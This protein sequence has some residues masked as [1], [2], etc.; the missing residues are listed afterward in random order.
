LHGFVVPKCA[1]FELLPM[2][3]PTSVPQ[4]RAALALHRFGFGPK[5]GTIDAIASDPRGAL[6]AE[7]DKPG[8][9]LVRGD[10]LLASAPAFRMVSDY[11]AERQARQ[12]LAARTQ[13]EREKREAEQR[14]VASAPDASSEQKM[15]AAA[16]PARPAAMATAETAR[17]PGEQIIIAEIKARLEAAL[18]ADIGFVERLVWFWSNHFCISADK[19]R[20]M[21]GAYEREA[22]RPHIL[23][24]FADLLLA[25]EGHPAMLFYLDNAASMGPNSVAGLNRNRG[26][27]EN[28]AREIL[29]L[30]TLGV[31]TG[32]SQDDVTTFAKV[33]TGWSFNDPG[34]DPVRG[35]EF[36]FNR[37]FHEPGVLKVIGRDYHD[38]GIEQGRAVLADLARHPATAAH[39]ATKLACHFVSDEPPPVLVTRLEAAFRDSDGDL[40]HT[41]KALVESP[42][43]WDEARTKLKRPGE[44]MVGMVRAAGVGSNGLRFGRNQATLG[45]PVWRPPSPRGHP[46]VTSAWIDGIGQRLDV[47]NSFAGRIAEQTDP[48]G[49]LETAL[50]PLARAETREGVARS[51][52]RQQA[53]VLLFMSSEFQRR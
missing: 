18:D 2:S 3:E 47:A 13:K 8:A 36:L 33:L 29:E 16:A 41:A 28:L 12:V 49:V 21:S 17:D 14:M 24:K 44:W 32:Y 27:N 4:A 35:G 5:P 42:E 50:G 43:A 26:L 20:S 6:L 37:R 48:N 52:S 31:R 30:H 10:G 1:S 19:I 40:R 53:L 45:E 46:D 22:I 25:A 11:N 23:G 51:D 39:V 15:E 38:T 9:G 34:N 7:L